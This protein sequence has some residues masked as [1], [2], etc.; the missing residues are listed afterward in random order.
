MH[1]FTLICI[2]IFESIRKHLMVLLPVPIKGHSGD[3]FNELADKLAALG[4][5]NCCE[6]GRYSKE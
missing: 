6:N 4:A 2:H 3:E 5:V 1:I